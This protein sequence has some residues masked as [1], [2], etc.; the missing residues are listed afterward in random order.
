MS[1]EENLHPIK[2][3]SLRTGLSAHVIRIWEK[4]YE[5]V[6]PQRTETNRR[7][8]SDEDIQRLTLMR[9]ASDRGHRIGQLARMPVSDLKELLQE[10][11]QIDRQRESL[12]SPVS[13][14]MTPA[15]IVS[16]C[17]QATRELDE[18]ALTKA[19]RSGAVQFGH[20]GLLEKVIGPL[21]NLIGEQWLK[22]QIKVAHEHFSSAV[23]RQF[24]GEIGRPYV[25]DPTAPRI[26]VA[27]PSGQLHEL[28]AVMVH[29]AAS[30]VG[31]NC[32]FI[33]CNISAEEIAGA[34]TQVAARAVALSIV[35]PADDPKL[36]DE[37][38]RLRHYL[39]PSTQI[40]VGGRSAGA[41]K[42]SL[43][44]AGAIHC[45]N[46]HALYPILEK[47]RTEKFKPVPALHD[48]YSSHNDHPV[49]PHTQ[50]GQSNTHHG[51]N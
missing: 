18:I 46:L 36:G 15:E 28:G 47:V 31:W 26:I 27:T 43:A 3:V 48:P 19:L 39:P 4:R 35:F 42:S 30:S 1:M 2:V 23:I 29:A 37:L 17:I 8:Y 12:A 40:I 34:A 24:L 51:F 6:V 41:Y 11:Q 44:Q 32:K 45:P 49:D 38:T 22:G 5:A 10:D 20:Q 14:S 9:L 50:N 21:T 16:V 7:L 13:R 33:G 25:N